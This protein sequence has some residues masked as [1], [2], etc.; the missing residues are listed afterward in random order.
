ME[1]AEMDTSTL[2][3]VQL[4][5]STRERQTSAF[6]RW[7]IRRPD[8]SNLVQTLLD[9]E[10]KV[11]LLTA[12]N[13]GSGITTSSLVLANE[14][15]RT[16]RGQ[17][18]LVDTSLSRNNLTHHAGLEQRPGFLDQ[19]FAAQPPG[20]KA[21]IEKPEKLGFDFMP[22]GLR[23]QYS[24]RLSAAPLRAL[25]D[26][27]SAEYRFVILD[28][29]AIYSNPDLL[30]LCAQ[31]DGVV[32]VVRSEET[33]W[34]VAQSAL[35]RLAQANATVLGSVFNARKHYMPKWVYDRL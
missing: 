11:I 22:L 18:L 20:L 24:E 10:R 3:P 23:Q 21:C 4:D 13:S 31:V 32:L 25:F 17:V 35:Q 7:K 5:E 19:V 14:V 26:A 34:E 8:E 12:P 28:G 9:Q 15:A 29:D 2:I 27:L 1:Q 33:R 16:S 30:S 6:A